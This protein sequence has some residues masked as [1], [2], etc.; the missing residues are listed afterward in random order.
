MDV[1]P[2]LPWLDVDPD[3]NMAGFLGFP[4]PPYLVGD[5]NTSRS[6]ESQNIDKNTKEKNDK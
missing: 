1:V 5:E 6:T 3:V 2:V 4:W